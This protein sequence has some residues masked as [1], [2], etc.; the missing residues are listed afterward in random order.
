[1]ELKYVPLFKLDLINPTTDPSES[2]ELNPTNIQGIVN[3][4]ELKVHESYTV[5]CIIV[6]VIE[7]SWKYS[8]SPLVQDHRHVWAWAYPFKQISRRQPKAQ[9][10]WRPQEVNL[11][12][13]VGA[14]YQPSSLPQQ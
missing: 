13:D 12:K 1:M 2:D 4:T 10:S 9:L 11:R 5:S 6:A 8:T 3:S 7:P 14:Q